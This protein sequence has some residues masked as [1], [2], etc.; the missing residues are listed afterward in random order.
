M[1]TNQRKRKNNII[2]QGGILA[3][4]GIIAK[5]IGLIK[6]IPVTN[7]IGDNGNSFYSAA[8]EVYAIIL[9]ISSY[10]LPLAV[11]KLVSARVSKGQY[12]NANKVFKGAL[13]FSVL[14]GGTASIFVFLYADFLSA[15]VMLEPMSYLALKIL[16]PAI[17]I[18]AIM[19]VFRGY[20]Q[21]LGTM[22]PT[23]VSQVIEQIFVAVVGVLGAYVLFGYGTKVGNLVQNEYFGASYGAAGATLGPGIG[24]LIGLIFLIFTF[25]L[26]YPHFK[27]QI[28]TDNSKYV[29]DYGQ[30]I[31]IL[32][33]TIVPVIL[34]TAVYNV[35]NVIDQRI[36]NQIMIEKGF[37]ELK[38]YNWGVFSGK[39]RV[40]TNV[41]IA[42]ASAMSASII[43]SLTSAIAN[44][45]T[46]QMK[47]K[48]S[49]VIRFT[50][51][52]AIPCAV[53]MGVLGRPIVDM[54]FNGEI[55]LAASLL[56]IGAISIVFYSLSTL[57]NGILQGINRMKIPVRNAVI[58]LVLHIIALYV[59]LQFFNMDIYAVVI[60]NV[61][62]ALIMCILNAMAIR[63]HAQY[64]QELVKTFGIPALCAGIMGVILFIAYQL[65][66][67]VMH[68]VFATCL[69][70]ILG[71]IVYF[72]LLIA[73]RGVSE[74]ELREVPMGSKII[75]AAKIIHIL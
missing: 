72:V 19:G 50:M 68:I 64:H 8:F 56:H 28:A 59:M 1:N 49:K 48:I 17:F 45:D 40:L 54:L 25:C 57:T 14:S 10:S 67:M 43:P 9:L 74:K 4:A 44:K 71:V 6:R 15:K 34:S 32:I 53:G 46:Q 62:F 31:K 26:Y 35:S 16:A 38:S 70:I 27:R 55:D 42:L 61:L 65:A 5:M 2:M 39:Y 66:S 18:V 51:I 63:K 37:A 11:S 47:D 24:A 23:A 7:I 75:K 52:I 20:F 13:I 36:Y 73:F 30:I 21:G 58:A 69:S 3:I 22:M 12:K 60:A 41:P 33:F 29:E